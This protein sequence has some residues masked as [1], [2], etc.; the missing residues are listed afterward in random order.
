MP[1]GRSFAQVTVHGVV[2]PRRALLAGGVTDSVDVHTFIPTRFRGSA[3]DVCNRA[4]RVLQARLAIKIHGACR[5]KKAVLLS[6]FKVDTT[7]THPRRVRAKALKYVTVQCIDRIVVVPLPIC[8]SRCKGR[9]RR[10][11]RHTPQG[12]GQ[13]SRVT[14]KRSA[15]QCARL[16]LVL[17]DLHIDE[18]SCQCQG[19]DQKEDGTE[20]KHVEHFYYKQIGGYPSFQA[21]ARVACRDVSEAS[22]ALLGDDVVEKTVA[23]LNRRSAVADLQA[24]RRLLKCLVRPQTSLVEKGERNT[25]LR[26][27]K[28]LTEELLGRMVP[29]HSSRTRQGD[30]RTQ[31]R[32]ELLK[33]E[34]FCATI[35]GTSR[36]LPFRGINTVRNRGALRNENRI[37]LQA[38]VLPRIQEVFP[39]APVAFTYPYIASLITKD[40]GTEELTTEGLEFFI[41]VNEVGDLNRVTLF[42]VVSHKGGHVFRGILVPAIAP[43]HAMTV[44]INTW[45]LTDTEYWGLKDSVTALRS[46]VPIGKAL[47]LPNDLSI[48]PEKRMV[49]P[50][51]PDTGQPWP[52]IHALQV[53]DEPCR[54]QGQCQHWS[55]MTAYVFLKEYANFIHQLRLT[56]TSPDMDLW[57]AFLVQ[58]VWRKL[59]QAGAPEGFN[60]LQR[61]IH[62]LGGK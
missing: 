12:R 55:F 22:R 34:K 37:D 18:A 9:S 30:E 60:A 20:C 27:I 25:F 61:E 28:D 7:I 50:Y 24:A 48:S 57:K 62:L 8:C 43:F 19:N 45:W 53:L 21:Y 3:W 58:Y 41:P 29:I 14:C 16:W 1:S 2:Y 56:A 40:D 32:R 52:T 38:R 23:L 13:Y 17:C 46:R 42:D 35:L 31:L 49:G 33:V 54:G 6:V 36:I 11:I 44:F 59:E 47:I 15:Y 26:D 10:R 39:Y 51:N 4:I 5:T